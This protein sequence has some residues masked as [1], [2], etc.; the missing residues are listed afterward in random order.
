[1]IF[2]DANIFIAYDNEKDVHH[3]QAKKLFEEIENG[4]YDH[5]FTSDYVFNEVVGVTLRKLSKERAI[6]LGN[7]ILQS[8]FIINIDD[9][10][11]KQAWQQFS[12]SDLKLSLVDY[13][14]VVICKATNALFIATFDKEFDKIE[15]IKRI[16]S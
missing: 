12:K 11:L 14:N 2:I 4:K 16:D 1:M 5:Y 8:I 6:I 15:G 7:Q 9:H 13:T 10:L 3:N